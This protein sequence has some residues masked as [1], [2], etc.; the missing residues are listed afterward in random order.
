MGAKLFRVEALMNRYEALASKPL[1]DH[2]ALRG[3]HRPMLALKRRQGWRHNERP[4][5]RRH[6]STMRT[7]PPPQEAITV[8]GGGASGPWGTCD[9]ALERPSFGS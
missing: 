5:S 2:L 1:D 9:E 7:S 4:T 6:W 8:W 3:H